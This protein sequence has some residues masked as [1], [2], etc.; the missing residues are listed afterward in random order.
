[1]KVKYIIMF[2]L[3][4]ILLVS[5]GGGKTASIDGPRL[6][7]DTLVNM[8]DFEGPRFKKSTI[9]PYQN[10]GNDT[11]YILGCLPSCECVDL[12]VS[13][14]ILPPGGSGTIAA[15]LDLSEKPLRTVEQPF[16]V[17]SNDP[18]HRQTDV[19]LVG[20]KK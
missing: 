18:V 8:G 11:L 17:L 16:F 4:A 5:C 14:T 2:F 20:T 12:V 13:D 3:L 19:I 6:K 7:I 1:M 10:V 9:I 15:Y